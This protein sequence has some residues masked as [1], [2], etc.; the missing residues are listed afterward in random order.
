MPQFLISKNQAKPLILLMV[1]PGG[2]PTSHNFNGL[3][4]PTGANAFFDAKGQFS[5]LSNVFVG[6]FPSAAHR[7]RADLIPRLKRGFQAAANA[8][9]CVVVSSDGVRAEAARL[10]ERAAR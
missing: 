1:G 10:G 4:C 3:V 5:E 8:A 7:H 2:V 9:W 6:A